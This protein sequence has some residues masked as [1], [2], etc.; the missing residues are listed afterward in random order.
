MLRSFLL[1]YA[2]LSCAAADMAYDCIIL[3]QL[4]APQAR[5]LLFHD[6]FTRRNHHPRRHCGEHMHT[7]S[8]YECS[9]MDE[10]VGNCNVC[11]ARSGHSLDI[12]SCLVV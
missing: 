1:C 4:D 11:L 6:E 3:M 10:R 8:Y 2:W 9:S 5:L 12:P 7:Y